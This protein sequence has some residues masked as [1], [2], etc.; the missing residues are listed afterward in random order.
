MSEQNETQAGKASMEKK[1]VALGMREIV[2]HASSIVSEG[3]KEN[4][5]D[6]MFGVHGGEFWA[7][8]D[9]CSREGIRMVTFRHEASAVYAAEA[10]AKVTGKAGVFYAD[11]GPGCANAANGVQQANISCTP[12]VGIVGAPYNGHEQ[13]YTIQP[14]YAEHMY[15]RITKWTQRATTDWSVKNLLYKAFKDAHGHPKGPCVVEVSASALLGWRTPD[16]VDRDRFA[17]LAGDNLYKKNWR[18]D[19]T[20]LAMPSP[21][22]DPEAVEEAVRKICEAK[23]PVIFAGDNVH[24]TEAGPELIKFAELAQVP[25]SGRRLARGAMPETHPMHASSRINHQ[26]MA[27]SDLLV[28][29]GMK[30]SFFDSNFGGDWPKGCIQINESHKQIF[31]HV[32][33][34]LII[35][36]GA[37]TVLKQMI[38]CYKNN[39]YKPHPERQEW[40]AKVQKL[41]KEADVRLQAKALKYKDHAPLHFGYMAKSVW[42]T[43]EDLYDGQNRIIVDGYSMSGFIQPFLKARYSGQ[44]MDPSENGNVGHG[45]G[46]A[47]GASFGDPETYKH[48]T[49]VL[50]GDSGIGTHGM[51]VETATRFNL[52]IVYVINNNDGWLGGMKYHYYG[53]NWGPLGAQDKPLGPQFTPDIRYEKIAEMCGGHGEY[54]SKPEEFRPALERALRAAQEG[55]TAVLNVI[56]DPTMVNPIH[57]SFGYTLAYGHIPWDELSKRG[58][59]IR[60]KYCFMLP[61]DEAGVP[62]MP[63]ADPWDPVPPEEWGI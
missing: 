49:I 52:P 54:I 17:K 33:T 22:G 2:P 19:E 42:D 11:S 36:G 28:S 6:T 60:R 3:M 1:E 18:G 5:V 56:T 27:E 10:Y 37:K 51:D 29:L 8:C 16:V 31:E 50:L 53:G 23:N 58:K 25:V 63:L 32:D 41:N 40:V 38:Q 35:L 15:S 9:N 13:C 48:P 34:S 43:C 12:L 26:L 4:H 55:K 61:W 39:N 7:M 62:E 57:Y 21:G 45:I 46:M 44:I 20:G 47:I 24:W 30:I 59:A 14:S